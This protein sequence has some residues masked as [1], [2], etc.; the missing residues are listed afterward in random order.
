MIGYTLRRLGY[1][2]VV[3]LLVTVFVFVVMRLVPGDAVSLQLQDTGVSRAEADALRAEFGL[4][5][6]VW[7]QLWDWLGNAARGD[8][9]VSF[10]SGEPVVE[11]FLARVPVTVQLGLLAMLVGSLLGIALGVVAA[12]TRGSAVDGAMRLFAVAFL[13]VPNF[14]VALLVLTMLALWFAWS[15]PIVYAGPGED[16]AGW[17]QQIAIPVLALG[18]GGMAAVARL[19]RSSMLESLGSDYI[20]TVRAKGVRERTVVV[21]HALRNSTIAVLTLLGLELATVLGGTVII[22]QMFA[23]PGT[24]QLIYQAVLDRDYPVVV[25]CTIFY[26][27][28]FVITIILL[29]LLYALVDPRIRT[30]RALS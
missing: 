26:A 3:M 7:A 15:P 20:R 18:T 29:D 14:V 11:M 10:Y 8:L 4:D 16:F 9:G 21:K 24:G 5:A 23:L 25:A 27:G 17:A 13:S 2:A 19:T 1:G 30:G 28:L 12:V 6:P 22:E